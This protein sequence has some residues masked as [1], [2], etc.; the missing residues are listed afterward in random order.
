MK[1]EHLTAYYEAQTSMLRLERKM[2]SVSEEVKQT[3]YDLRTAQETQMNY[4]GSPK[5]L[6]DKLTGKKQEKEEILSLAVRKE[7]AKV[8]SLR[9]EKELLEK[10]KEDLEKKI[11]TLPTWEEFD[12]DAQWAELE[13]G[14]CTEVLRPMLEEIRLALLEYRRLLRGE[15]PVLTPDRQQ[16]ITSEPNLLAKKTIPCLNRLKEAKEILGQPLSVGDYLEAPDLWL[17]GVAA[18]HNRR[19][20]VNE[21]LDQVERLQKIING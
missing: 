13:S 3:T 17:F 12:H 1:Q 18:A 2:E 15:F 7:Q 14:Y 21:A 9:R 19:D 10:Q 8:D 16:E 6:L 20:R 4:W 5:A 11:Q